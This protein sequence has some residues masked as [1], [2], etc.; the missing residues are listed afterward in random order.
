MFSNHRYWLGFFALFLPIIV[1]VSIVIV[2]QFMLESFD[3]MWISFTGAC[4]GSLISGL[5]MILIMWITKDTSEI[6]QKMNEKKQYCNELSDLV[7]EYCIYA[8]YIKTQIL[9]KNSGTSEYISLL[10]RYVEKVD[11]ISF[12]LQMKLK[13]AE[14]GEEIA[15]K[16]EEIKELIIGKDATPEKIMKGTDELRKLTIE[17]IKNYTN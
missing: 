8:S 15:N 10:N 3:S 13:I 5:M 16:L 14:C 1:G 2:L 17:F 6:S 4:V 11:L 9:L 12:K 7:A